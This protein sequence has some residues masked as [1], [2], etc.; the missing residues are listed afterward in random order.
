MHPE[1]SASAPRVRATLGVYSQISAQDRVLRLLV[2]DAETGARK[3][4]E[5]AGKELLVADAFGASRKRFHRL[6]ALLAR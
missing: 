6:G 2:Y 4:R 3:Q 5:R 1:R